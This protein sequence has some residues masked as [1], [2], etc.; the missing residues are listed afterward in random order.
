MLV[1]GVL[2]NSSHKFFQEWIKRLK[3]I[4][5]RLIVKNIFPEK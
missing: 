3:W 4:T 2:G 5:A 1:Y